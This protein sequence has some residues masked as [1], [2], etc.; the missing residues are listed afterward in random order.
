M[1]TNTYIIGSA[2]TSFSRQPDQTLYSLF[3]GV[4]PTALQDANLLASEVDAIFVANYSGG[5]FN[6]QEHLAPYAVNVNQ[7]FR[8]KP[9]FRAEG[10]C[11]SGSSAIHLAQMAI[12]SGQIKNALVI[13]VEKMTNLDTK[14]VTDALAKASYYPTEGAKGYTFP[15]LFAEFAKGWLKKYQYQPEQLENWLAQISSKAYSLGAKN[16]Y[17]QLTKERSVEDLL[18]M[19]KE[20]NPIIAEPL[21]MHDCSPISDGAA[22]IVLSNDSRANNPVHLRKMVTSCDYLD[23]VNSRKPNHFLEAASK[24]ISDVLDSQNMSINDIQFAEVHDCFTIAELLMYSALGLAE[25]GKEFEALE[26]G[27]VLP[28]GQCVINPSG[29]LKSKGHPVGATGVSMHALSYRQLC[30][31]ASGYQVES[32]E[33]ALVVNLGGS[34]STNVVSLLSRV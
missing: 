19:P 6:N 12:Q 16:P 22:A 28:G 5:S 27:I 9:M 4:I 18:N 34:A 7:A 11:A 21:R 29:G 14:G 25:P 17:A 26:S 15:G 8:F 33:N 31:K 23:I 30:D 3:S 10:A 13:G 24:A 20:K 2:H 32:A 1:T